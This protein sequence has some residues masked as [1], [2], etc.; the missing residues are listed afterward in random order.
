MPRGQTAPALHAAAPPEQEAQRPEPRLD[1]RDGVAAV[2]LLTLV[3]GVAQI[4]PPA[5]WIVF[6]VALL[7]VA[8]RT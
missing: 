2:G 5:A 8:W 7:L 6:G 3:I 1:A 4:F